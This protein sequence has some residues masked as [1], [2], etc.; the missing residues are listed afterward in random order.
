MQWKAIFLLRISQNNNV[1][2][3][4]QT[5]WTGWKPD[6]PLMARSCSVAMAV[7]NSRGRHGKAQPA[8]TFLNLFLLYFALPMSLQ[9]S[10]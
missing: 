7:A 8:A 3:T 6:P 5:N 2:D 10:L 4:E 1:L 9:L